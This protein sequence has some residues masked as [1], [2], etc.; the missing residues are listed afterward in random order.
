MKW[1]IFVRFDFSFYF[2]LLINRFFFV[3]FF[4]LNA[5]L[6]GIFIIIRYKIWPCTIIPFI[7]FVVFYKRIIIL[8][9]F[10]IKLELLNLSLPCYY[11][12]I[13]GELFFPT[14][15]NDYYHI[16]MIT[17]KTDNFVCSPRHDGKPEIWH[18]E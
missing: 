6:V 3:F 9:Y 2:V 17:S 5:N 12:L 7:F 8:E 10:Q 16:P 11:D 15:S 13:I 14:A 18:D 4:V 1:K